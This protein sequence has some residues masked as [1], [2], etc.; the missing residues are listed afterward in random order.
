MWYA[1]DKQT[2]KK[3][4]QSTNYIMKY[5]RCEFS[6]SQDLG[7]HVNIFSCNM[8]LCPLFICYACFDFR[9]FSSS[10]SLFLQFL[11]TYGLI[12]ILLFSAFN[13]FFFVLFL[14][15]LFLI[16]LRYSFV[17]CI[18]ICFMLDVLNDYSKL[19][20]GFTNPF[21]ETFSNRY[22]EFFIDAN[23]IKSNFK[24]FANLW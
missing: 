8:R 5:E 11:S 18:Y 22:V 24:L 16:Y 3:T 23:P 2:K 17:F 6:S 10:F 14:L 12:F 21:S 7:A 1:T 15:F 20:F 19:F 4:K 13:K 9:I